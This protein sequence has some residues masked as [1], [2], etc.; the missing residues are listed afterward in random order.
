M[1]KKSPLNDKEKK[2][3]EE[4]INELPKSLLKKYVCP[5]FGCGFVPSKKDTWFLKRHIRNCEKSPGFRH[6]FQRILKFKVYDTLYP[7]RENP[8]IINNGWGFG[9]NSN[10]HF[11]TLLEDWH[12]KE[13]NMKIHILLLKDIIASRRL[14]QSVNMRHNK[15]YFFFE[16]SWIGKEENPEVWKEH[17]DLLLDLWE[18]KIE[19][20]LEYKD[21]YFG[22][23]EHHDY[24]VIKQVAKDI[25]KEDKFTDYYLEE[26]R[27]ENIAN[28]LIS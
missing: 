16:D 25:G 9:F 27:K 18:K 12:F 13:T 28:D 2:I 3:N 8:D 17:H 20:V 4:Y 22:Q 15:V 7:L 10:S 21:F 23:E 5:C 11:V 24:R 14:E 26:L 19:E 1:P 6:Y